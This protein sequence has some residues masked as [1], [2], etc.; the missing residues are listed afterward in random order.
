VSRGRATIC[1][2]AR[3][4][5]YQQCRASAQPRAQQ[6]TPRKKLSRVFFR[7]LT[8]LAGRRAIIALGYREYSTPRERVLRTLSEG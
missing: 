3:N 4:I 6:V 1:N 2:D 7:H 8:N 5:G